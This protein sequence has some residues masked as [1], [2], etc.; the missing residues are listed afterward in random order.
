MCNEII[1]F[2]KSLLEVNREKTIK[3]EHIVYDIKLLVIACRRV[4]PA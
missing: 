3:R 2:V 4:V 1:F